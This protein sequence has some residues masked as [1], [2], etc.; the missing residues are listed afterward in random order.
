VTHRLELDHLVYATPDLEA[1][2]ADLEALLDVRAAYGGRHPGRGTRNALIALSELSYLEIVGPDETRVDVARPRWLGVDALTNARLVT[3]AAKSVNIESLAANAARNGVA[4]GR[5]TSGSRQTTDGT[6]LR[7]QLTDP[8]A[9]LEG[10]VIPFFIEWGTT[11]HPASTAPRGPEL[12]SLRAE[13][14]EPRRVERAMSVLGIELPVT[15]APQPRL[16]ARLRTER[17]DVDLY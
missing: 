5:V 6:V 16:I 2:I 12:L 15:R 3:W 7:W 8:A 13:H 14:P 11:V 17:G 10:G 1:T 4:L 9:M